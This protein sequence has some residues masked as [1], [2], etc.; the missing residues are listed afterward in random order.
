MPKELQRKTAIMKNKKIEALEKLI[1]LKDE[2]IK[3][4]ERQVQLL[5]SQPPIYINTPTVPVQPYTPYLPVNPQWPWSQPFY[6]NP[7][8]ITSGDPIIMDPNKPYTVTTTLSDTS[9][10][11]TL[12][13]G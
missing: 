8:I 11:I 6:G 4:L 2:T 10:V 7:Y 1:A 5:K 3:E 12:K 9:N 13:Q